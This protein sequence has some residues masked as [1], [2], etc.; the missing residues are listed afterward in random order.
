MRGGHFE[1][2]GRRNRGLGLGGSGGKI[3]SRSGGGICWAGRDLERMVISS[4][5]KTEAKFLKRADEMRRLVEYAYDVFR[6][7]L[8]PSVTHRIWSED[9]RESGSLLRFMV[10]TSRNFTET[11]TNFKKDRFRV[12]M[13]IN[14]SSVQLIREVLHGSVALMMC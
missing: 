11:H 7:D 4:G 12:V 5:E 3:G 14:T 6:L 13:Y 1:L 2:E 9:M 10:M 8:E